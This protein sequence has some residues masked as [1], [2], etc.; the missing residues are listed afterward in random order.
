MTQPAFHDLVANLVLVTIYSLVGGKCASYLISSHCEAPLISAILGIAI[1]TNVAF[2]QRNRHPLRG[3]IYGGLCGYF[4]GTLF[5][6]LSFF[7]HP[8]TAESFHAVGIDTPPN[9]ESLFT[10]ISEFSLINFIQS[11]SNY[12]QYRRYIF[13]PT[14]SP[15]ITNRPPKLPLPQRLI[16]SSFGLFFGAGFTV[17]FLMFILGVIGAVEGLTSLSIKSMF[18]GI[19]N[20]IWT[21]I[22]EFRTTHYMT[23]GSISGFLFSFARFMS[24]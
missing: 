1:W 5:H 7:L 8:P 4:I 11:I 17:I 21:G 19:L 14:F 16:L 13:F 6:I 2:V 22:F 18:E 20:M 23:P 3:V 12:T 10:S 24:I 15:H 9:H